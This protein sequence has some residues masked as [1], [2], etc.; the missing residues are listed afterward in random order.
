MDDILSSRIQDM[1]HDLPHLVEETA[2]LDLPFQMFFLLLVIQPSHRGVEPSKY[3]FSTIPYSLQ[4][5][6]LPS[7]HLLRQHIGQIIG[8]H[9]G[10]SVCCNQFLCENLLN[11]L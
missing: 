2:Q 6:Q 10:L 4:L 3:D 9:C 11:R 1:L 7:D 5:H 8:G